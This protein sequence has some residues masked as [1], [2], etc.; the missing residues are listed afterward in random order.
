MNKGHAQVRVMNHDSSTTN[1][2][3]KLRTIFVLIR[4]RRNVASLAVSIFSWLV[5]I[6]ASSH[7]KEDATL[8]A[9]RAVP[10]RRAVPERPDTMD[11]P[12]TPDRVDS[13]ALACSAPLRPVALLRA[14][15]MRLLAEPGLNREGRK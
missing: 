2:A 6:K 13:R 7:T 8:A 10:G 15:L 1:V 11:M 12:L 4:V 3:S 5:V 9:D 14:E